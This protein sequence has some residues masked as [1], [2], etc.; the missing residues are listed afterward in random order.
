MNQVGHT[1]P[2]K[3]KLPKDEVNGTA[4]GLSSISK[5]DTLQLVFK[6]KF[7]YIPG[8]K[9]AISTFK[10]YVQN[11]KLNLNTQRDHENNINNCL[12]R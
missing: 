5:Y 9:T 7:G 1:A 8:S 2:N 12:Q 11:K 6:L 10:R 4:H 3:T